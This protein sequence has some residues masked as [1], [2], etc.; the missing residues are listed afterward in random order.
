M[1]GKKCVWNSDWCKDDWSAPCNT[2]TTQFTTRDAS[3]C[4]NTT[5]WS[6]VDCNLYRSKGGE[7]MFY[8]KRCSANKQHCYYPWYTK[9][10]KDFEYRKALLPPTCQDKSDRIF[11]MNTR[12]NITG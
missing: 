12:C 5:F 3:L 9:N 10:T 6:N 4:S 8:G 7:V 2:N 1:C 11:A